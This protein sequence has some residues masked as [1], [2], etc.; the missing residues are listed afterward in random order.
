MSYTNTLND[1]CTPASSQ[2][3]QLPSNPAAKNISAS[4]R[5]TADWREAASSP[6][7]SSL[8][9]PSTL[10][11][12]FSFLALCSRLPP[13]LYWGNWWLLKQ[14]SD[15]MTC[16]WLWFILGAVDLSHCSQAIRISPLMQNPKELEYGGW[17]AGALLSAKIKA[18]E[19]SGACFHK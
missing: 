15:L 11:F 19:H 9:F 18:G 10:S 6:Q 8:S 12:V 1:L 4:V 16:V 5:L 7:D 3:I 17:A 2:I 14:N 13:T